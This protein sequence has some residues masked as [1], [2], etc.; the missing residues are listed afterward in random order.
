MALNP[1]V[2]EVLRGVASDYQS[3]LYFLLLHFWLKLGQSDLWLRLPTA[4]LGAALVPLVYVTGRRF[5]S[6]AAGLWA[7]L[8]SAVTTYQVYFSRYPRSYILLALLAVLAAYTLH[9]ALQDAQ[10]RRWALHGLTVALAL[11]TH[12]YAFFLLPPLWGYAAWRLYLRG[13]HQF[14]PLAVTGGLALLSYLPWAGV[15]L[16]QWGQVQA[17]ADAWIEPVSRDSLKTLYDWLWF[18]TRAEYGPGPDLLLRGGRY[19][20]TALLLLAL[21]RS[22]RRED[23][24]LVVGLAVGPTALAFL[25]SLLVIPLWDP[26]YLVVLSPFLALWLGHAL[27]SLETPWPRRGAA[28]KP[29]AGALLVAMSL[30]PLASLYLDP[31][32]RAPEIRSASHWTHTRYLEGDLI[33]H[34]NEQ[35]YLPALWYDHQEAGS[36]GGSEQGFP[37]PCLWQS[38]PDAWCDR[39]PYRVGYVNLERQDFSQAVASESRVWLTVLYNHNWPGEA[40]KA[41]ALV[42]RLRGQSFRVGQA[43]RFIGVE[44]YELVRAS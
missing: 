18:K 15:A 40:A 33:L 25:F 5:F 30:P 38:L 36:G 2:G 23:L 13:R 1:T 26:R 19:L 24:W 22:R 21:W 20:F 29:L 27:A 34:I 39:S 43:A 10:R 35:S 42:E 9:L 28:L 14:A 31:A 4:L 12:P 16:A 17:G 7:A 11:Y 41:Q 8:F 3:P 37:A 32:F 6:P 44:V